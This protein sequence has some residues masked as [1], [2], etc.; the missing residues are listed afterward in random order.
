MI[1]DL[2]SYVLQINPYDPCV[3]NNIIKNKY[4]TGVWHVD[5]LKVSHV[6]SLAQQQDFI[7]Q[8]VVLYYNWKLIM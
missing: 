5:D 6:D 2:E 1:K 3:G 4:M 7:S 8:T